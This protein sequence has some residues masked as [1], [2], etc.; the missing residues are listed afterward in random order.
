MK[1][2]TFA[3]QLS[4]C[5]TEGGCFVKNDSP[6]AFEGQIHVRLLNLITGGTADMKKD[7]VSLAAGPNVAEWF[8]AE[9]VKTYSGDGQQLL[10]QTPI[11]GAGDAPPKPK[12]TVHQQQIPLDRQNFTKIPGVAGEAKCEATCDAKR[13]ACV[14]FTYIGWPDDP[15]N[16]ACF[17]YGTVPKLQNYPGA[18]RKP[19]S[20]STALSCFSRSFCSW[21]MRSLG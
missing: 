12:Y 1:I 3:D 6:F 19:T 18:V 21:I 15:S 16:G 13:G 10:L 5:N 11:I 9:S 17:F 7:T 20:C 14:G 2:S 4:T 8:C